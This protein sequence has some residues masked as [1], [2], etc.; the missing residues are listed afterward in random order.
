[1][2][3]QVQ[4]QTMNL[5]RC[6]DKMLIYSNK[7]SLESSILCPYVD[8]VE[9]DIN[10]IIKKKLLKLMCTKQSI[11]VQF[12]QPKGTIYLSTWATKRPLGR[13]IIITIS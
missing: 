5:G 7:K 9:N 10:E 3:T 1:M 11:K 13:F 12:Y 8:T 6:Y 2:V 4:T